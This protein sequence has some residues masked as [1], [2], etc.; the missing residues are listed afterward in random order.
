MCADVERDREREREKDYYVVRCDGVSEQFSTC[1]QNGGSGQIVRR[2]SSFCPPRSV[3]Q[4]TN[5][6]VVCVCVLFS[7]IPVVVVVVVVVGEGS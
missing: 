3:Y 1:R 5:S 7:S 2:E 4:V 6:S